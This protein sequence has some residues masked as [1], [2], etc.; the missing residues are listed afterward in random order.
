MN[1]LSVQMLVFFWF[2]LLNNYCDYSLSILVGLLN[3]NFKLYTLPL[4]LFCFVFVFFYTA[5]RK[6][7]FV[8]LNTCI[9]VYVKEWIVFVLTL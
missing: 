8:F 7:F 3:R 5:T 6:Y 9:E 2:N 4:V 1:K